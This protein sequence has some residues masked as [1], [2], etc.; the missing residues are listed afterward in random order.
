MEYNQYFKV[1]DYVGVYMKLR[2]HTINACE[3][4]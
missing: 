2:H 3:M 4:L 1:V